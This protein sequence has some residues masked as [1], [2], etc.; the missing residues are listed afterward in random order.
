MHF[1]E[2]LRHCVCLVKSTTLTMRVSLQNKNNI[3][4][5]FY[6][7]YLYNISK[8]LNRENELISL[9]SYSSFRA[10]Y[11]HWLIWIIWKRRYLHQNSVNVWIVCPTQNILELSLRDSLGRLNI[12]Q[13][14]KTQGKPRKIKQRVYILCKTLQYS[15]FLKQVPVN[16]YRCSGQTWKGYTVIEIKTLV[17]ITVLP[18]F[19]I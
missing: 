4:S 11:Q 16:R 13:L 17:L 3:N 5:S 6:S 7:R 15:N 19:W 14:P 2:V 12:V 18:G 1:K 9:T 10:F 8:N